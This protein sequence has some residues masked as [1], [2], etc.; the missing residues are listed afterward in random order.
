MTM[1]EDQFTRLFTYMQTR[2]DGI[3]AKLD[4]KADKAQTDKLYQ[5]IDDI[6]GTLND[7]A[8]EQAIINHRH[9][10]WIGQ[11]AKHTGTRLVPEQ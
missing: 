8:Q 9:G 11:L 7:T 5:L 10:Q 2:F 1:S 4:S 3:D 6:A